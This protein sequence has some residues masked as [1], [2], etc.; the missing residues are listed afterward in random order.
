MGNLITSVPSITTTEYDVYIKPLLDDPQI[1][2]LPLA[3]TYGNMPREIFFNSNLDKITGAGGSCGWTTKGSGVAFTK[4]TLNPIEVKAPVSQ[5]YSV[6]LKKLFGDKLPDGARR[7]ELTPEVIDFMTTQKNYAF[8]RDLLSFL[9]LGDTAVTPDD[10]YSLMDGMYTRL[11]AGSITAEADGTLVVDAGALTSSSLS[12]ANFFATMNA[13]YNAQPRALKSIA[14]ANKN[15]IWTEALYDLYL[16]YLEVATQ[17]TAGSVQTQYVTEGLTATSFKGIPIVVVS[18]VDER[19]D[20]DFLT[21]SPLAPTNPYRSILT[22][23][24]NHH[25]MMDDTAF[26]DSQMFIQQPEDLVWL[27]G[28]ALIDYQYGYGELTVIAGF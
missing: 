15:W 8:N 1:N 21:G 26:Q 13:V 6:L 2:Q 16:N 11:K 19:L 20:S 14:K 10:Y 24:G 28:S 23:A 4:K 9:F 3:F 22:T 27:T 5:C 17:N 7:G 12:T 25:L 18:I